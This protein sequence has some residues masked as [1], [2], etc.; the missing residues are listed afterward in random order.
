MP[1][2][3]KMRPTTAKVPMTQLGVRIGCQA[4]SFCCL[5]GV[6]TQ[7]QGVSH[8]GASTATRGAAAPSGLR[9]FSSAM[10]LARFGF[11]RFSLFLRE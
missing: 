9:D 7:I 2:G 4:L 5:K 6:S 8:S 3:M 10:S 11:V 1:M